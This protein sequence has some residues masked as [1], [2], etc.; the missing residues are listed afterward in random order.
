MHIPLVDLKLQYAAHADEINRAVQAVMERGDF[1]LGSD[2]R[3]F[4][5]EFAA[6]CQAKYA[7]GLATG[8]DAL[9]LGLLACGVGPGDEVITAA[10]SFVASASAISFTGATPVF[11]DID[12]R[13]YTLDPQ[14]VEQAIT[15]RT[16]AI[17][18]VHLY[19]QPADMEAILAL[20]RSYGL[21]VVEDACQAH[22][23]ETQGRRVGSLGDVAAFSF[24]PGKNLGAYGDGGAAT[25]NDPDIAER[26]TM[27]RNYGQRVK[28]QHDFLAFN[29]RLDTIQA[30]V[31]RVK[32]R[33]MEAWNAQRRQA[34]AHYSCL[35]HDQ[36]I[37]TPFVTPGNTSV[38]HLYVIRSQ[39]RDELVRFLNAQGIGAGIHYPIPIPF[40]RAY[41]TL[42]YRPGDFPNAEAACREVLSLPLYPEITPAQIEQVGA[43][44]ADFQGTVLS[45]AA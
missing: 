23:A 34:A 30:A 7:V 11:A 26:L 43:A 2:V 25:T 35:L 10:N 20:A 4:E 22:G 31:L 17:L 42:G 5:E 14:S 12:P 24:Y 41:C 45:K 8:T 29:S 44:I 15:E 6:F 3:A 16:K 9:H 1:I 32:L 19:G 36:Q 40:Q 27:L 38:F 39:Q 33:Y 13:T 37:P 21:K 18:P 28:Y